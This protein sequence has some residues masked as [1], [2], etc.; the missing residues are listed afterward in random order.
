MY[1]ILWTFEV[2]PGFETEFE[3]VYAADGDW[4]QLFRQSPG[5]IGTELLHDVE[6]RRHY[7]TID[8]WESREDFEGCRREFRT[9]YDALDLRCAPLRVN[10]RL[11]GRFQ[12]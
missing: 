2:R 9:A 1:V 11:V 3:R 7:S 4:A 8:R 10:Q 5:F 12:E 6:R